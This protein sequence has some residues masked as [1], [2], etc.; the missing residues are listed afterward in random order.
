[1]VYDYKAREST[2]FH[3]HGDMPQLES[4]LWR[5]CIFVWAE[6][7]IV[8]SC[9]GISHSRVVHCL[10]ATDFACDPGNM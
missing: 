1:M 4:H 2:G 3:T 7:I 10:L 5:G 6:R 9:Q 8:Q